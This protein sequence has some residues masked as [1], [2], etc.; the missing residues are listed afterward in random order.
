[1]NPLT[2]FSQGAALAALLVLAAPARAQGP[3]DEKPAP[4]PE[5]LLTTGAV[6]DSPWRLEIHSAEARILA[7]HRDYPRLALELNCDGPRRDGHYEGI[8]PIIDGRR[9]EGTL[10]SST[11]SF[12]SP[13]HDAGPTERVEVLA[14]K[15][16]LRVRFEGGRYSRLHPAGGDDPVFLEA[17]FTVNA[18][19]QLEARL[20]GIYYIFPSRANTSVE[21]EALQGKAT[22]SITAASPKSMEYFEGVTHLSVRDSVNGPFTLK[23]YIQRL[24]LEAHPADKGDVFEFDLDHTYKDRGQKAV[25]STLCLETPLN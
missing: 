23:T 24:Q 8:T 17:V 4:R 22:R 2:V 15:P 11:V 25:L 14:M 10:Y 6:A 9:L 5:V 7:R 3:Y 13:D 16:M 20:N 12:L 19:H 21:I 1:M 18:K